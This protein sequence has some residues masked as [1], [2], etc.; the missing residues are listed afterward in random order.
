MPLAEV[1]RSSLLRWSVRINLQC[2]AMTVSRLVIVD[3]VSGIDLMFW[4]SG[5]GRTLVLLLLDHNSLRNLSLLSLL[6]LNL[7]LL[8]EQIWVRDQA[9]A[10][11][12][13]MVTWHLLR[14]VVVLLLAW[15]QMVIVTRSRRPSLVEYH[16]IGHWWLRAE[17]DLTVWL[18]WVDLRLALI[19]ET[20]RQGFT[21]CLRK[22]LHIYLRIV[23]HWA[24]CQMVLLLVKML[25]LQLTLCYRL[26]HELSLLLLQIITTVIIDHLLLIIVVSV[27]IL[28][29]AFRESRLRLMPTYDT[30]LMW[31]LR[32]LSLVSLHVCWAFTFVFF[33]FRF[34]RRG[35]DD[36][37]ALLSLL[38]EQIWWE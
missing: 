34:F 31:W 6:M 8:G 24:K 11:R 27:V 5:R 28:W 3:V 33:S 1:I 32:L 19:E 22:G 9:E 36:L 37:A 38:V 25:L 21:R 16:G 23:C 17:G 2:L 4:C 14:R 26:L 20:H 35:R 7:L 12:V 13:H 18:D 15:L 29:E 30:V 10:T